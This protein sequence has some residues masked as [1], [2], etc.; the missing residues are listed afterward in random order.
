MVN[1]GER[2]H[3][4]PGQSTQRWVVEGAGRVGWKVAANREH[5][6]LKPLVWVSGRVVILTMMMR[7]G[8]ETS[9]RGSVSQLGEV[10]VKPLSVPASRGKT[11]QISNCSIELSS[12]PARME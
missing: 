11:C 7:V 10:K 12:L 9:A 1:L 3:G 5:L 2:I 6:R 4:E 8:V